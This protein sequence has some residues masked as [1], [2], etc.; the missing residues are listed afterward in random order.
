MWNFIKNLFNNNFFQNILL[1]SIIF[2][3]FSLYLKQCEST[4]N[5]Q[6]IYQQNQK[7]LLDSLMITKNLV[8]EIAYEKYTLITDIN[9]LKNINNKLASEVEKISGEVKRISQYNI[10][11]ELNEVRMLLD[12]IKEKEYAKG[13]IITNDWKTSIEDGS[14]FTYIEGYTDAYLDTTNCKIE[15]MQS[16][17]KNLKYNLEL[18]TYTKIDKD[19]YII[20]G[21][22]PYQET[23]NLKINF[24]SYDIDPKLKDA[25]DSYNKKRKNWT[26]SFGP[27]IGYGVF[28]EP[29]IYD[30]N[31]NLLN[32][33][34][35]SWQF[36][37]GLQ[38]GF[39][40]LD[41]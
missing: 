2:I 34:R 35:N 6:K 36:G 13:R 16:Y 29:N 9:N 23:P 8:G 12:Q 24:K 28:Y 17:L 14:M 37:L 15:N 5:L 11:Y 38:L 20:S 41:F 26:L 3:I 40:I 33:Y 31:Y 21:A 39:K 4:N 22:K 7:A 25:W 27:Y 30:K 32:S 1:L 19:G 10:S 18:I